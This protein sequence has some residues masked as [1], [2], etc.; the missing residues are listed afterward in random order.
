MMTF[1]G[2]QPSF[3]LTEG[4]PRVYDININQY[5]IYVHH[6]RQDVLRS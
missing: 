5:F 2:L 4:P 3:C 1:S 6:L